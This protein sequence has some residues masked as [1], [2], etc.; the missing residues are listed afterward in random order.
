MPRYDAGERHSKLVR[1]SPEAA[2]AALRELT[3]ADL[4]VSSVLLRLRCGPSGWF[5]GL[6]EAGRRLVLDSIPP[7]ELAANWP[8]E[9]LLGDVAWY[10]AASPTR[11][12]QPS[13]LEGFAAFT[14][15][16]WNKAAM[17][18]GFTAVPGGT[19]VRTE[20]RV[21][22][23]DARAR[24]IFAVYWKLV[25]AGSALIRREILAALS[26]VL[27]GDRTERQR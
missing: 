10:P 6:G 21:C 4:P 19:Q 26:K 3:I 16:G 8:N 17:Y 12:E 25:G 18:F 9:L 11:P 1:A 7:R 20:T 13:D 22:S 2:F 27:D 24:R 14:E 23:T 5:A 15:P